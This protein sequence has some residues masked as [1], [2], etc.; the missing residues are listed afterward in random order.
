MEAKRPGG[1]RGAVPACGAG[2]TAAHTSKFREWA[3]PSVIKANPFLP[4]VLGLVSLAHGVLP[5][6]DCRGFGGSREDD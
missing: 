2:L 1:L 3:L 6:E 4:F 5:A